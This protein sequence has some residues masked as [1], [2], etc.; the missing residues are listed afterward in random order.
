MVLKALKS[1]GLLSHLSCLTKYRAIY[2][3]KVYP[4]KAYVAE[5]QIA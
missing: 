5:K 3:M 2:I 1:W 4:I